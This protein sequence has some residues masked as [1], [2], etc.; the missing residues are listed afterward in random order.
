MWKFS[1]GVHSVVYLKI[2]DLCEKVKNIVNV[3]NKIIRKA[4]HVI[5]RNLDFIIW[6][7]RV[8]NE[9]SEGK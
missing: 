8:K 4:F 3:D 9:F 2:E 6:V 7:L 5:S 1:K